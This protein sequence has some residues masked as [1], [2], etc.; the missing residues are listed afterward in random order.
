MKN[1]SLSEAIKTIYTSKDWVIS[2]FIVTDFGAKG[3]PGFDN[4]ESFQKAIDAAYNDGGGVVYVPSGNY[5]FRTAFT[6]KKSVTVKD[7]GTQQN[8]KPFYE[9]YDYQYVLS[10]PPSVQLR[11]DWADPKKHGGKVLGTVLEVRVGKDSPNHD[12]YIEAQW[13]DS[14]A[15]NALRSTKTSIAD[16]FIQMNGGTGITNLSIWYPEQNIN[17]IKP[18]PWTLYQMSGNS[19]TIENVTLVNSYNGF[20]SAPSELHYVYNSYITA[21]KTGIEIHICTDIGRVENIK[22][23]P[24]YWA[25]SGLENTPSLEVLTAYTKANATGFKMHRS[26]WEY[27]SDLYVSGYNV[28]MRVGR[29]PG[30]KDAPNA[31][32]YRLHIENCVTA[33]E[34]DDVNPYGLLFSDSKFKVSGAGSRAVSVGSLFRTAIQFNGVDFEGPIFSAGSGGILSFESCTFDYGGGYDITLNSGSA[35]LAQCDFATPENH[36]YLGADVSALKSINSGLGCVL[37][38]KNDS[39]SASVEIT[40]DEQYKFESIPRNILTDIAVQP[41]AATNKV[42]RADLPRVRGVN[43]DRPTVDISVEL[44]I[45]LDAAA[46]VG[47]GTVYLPGGRYL[48]DKP[49]IIPTGVE[50]RGTWDVQHHTQSGGSAIFTNH[51]INDGQSVPDALPLIRLQKSAGIR[52]LKIIQLGQNTGNIPIDIPDRKA[53]IECPFTI[54]GQG[55]DVY[56]INVTLPNADKGIDLASYDTSRHYVEY[57]AGSLARAG[58]WVGGGTDRGFI[59][60]VKFNPHY[61]SRLPNGTQGYPRTSLGNFQRENYSALKFGD[62]KNQTVFFNFVFGSKN[63]MHFLRDETTGRNPKEMT[64]IGHGTDGSTFGLFVENADADTKIILINSELVT[65]Y[66]EYKAYV[67]MGDFVNPDRVHKDA[68]LMLYNSAFWGNVDNAV[69]VNSG[70]VRLQ[71]ANIVNTGNPGIKIMG[72]KAHIYNTYFQQSDRDYVYISTT[73]KSAELTNNFYA[74][75]TYCHCVM[76]GNIYGSDLFASL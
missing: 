53:F 34:A 56:I 40:A 75:K 27:V 52:G 59:R 17:D 21:L 24:E 28:G 51:A 58:I 31:Q 38:I 74:D 41:R 18:Y 30:F 4:R 20:Y 1:F 29:E 25:N 72:G 64:V 37:D 68:V 46:S 3:E 8:P 6:E 65:L 2:D 39:S 12:G 61:G 45:A 49:V 69:V 42:F 76:T 26:D 23:S 55:T 13:R 11:G 36:V 44:Q 5:E 16:R 9:W 67:L 70:T 10:L 63:G 19:A 54:Q 71:Q 7:T 22:I 47:G 33:L 14:Q 48:L 73:A 62:V 57:F 32:F 50:L 60:N 15:R 66:A 43:N 35:L